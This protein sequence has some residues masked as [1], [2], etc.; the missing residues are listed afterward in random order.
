MKKCFVVTSLL[1]ALCAGLSGEDRKSVSL[2]LKETAG[3]RRY[4]FP[5]NT[6][7]P[8]A[9]G[10]LTSAANVRLMLNEAET[11]VECTAESQW[12]DGSIQWLAVDFNATV[13]PRRRS[14]TASNTA[15]RSSPCRRPGRCR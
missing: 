7:V 1:L 13:G 8:F 6:R 12:P 15:R 5:V 9:K 10:S 14:P 4:G 3:I 2:S 11:P